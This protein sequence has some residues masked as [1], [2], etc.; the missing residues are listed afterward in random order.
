MR[1]GVPAHAVI[2]PS[3]FLRSEE[4]KPAGSPDRFG[5]SSPAKYLFPYCHESLRAGNVHHCGFLRQVGVRLVIGNIPCI[6]G[7][8]QMRM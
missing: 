6:G 8:P 3:V 5:L 7:L 1:G 2:Q 4:E